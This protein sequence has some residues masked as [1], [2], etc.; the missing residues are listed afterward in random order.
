[1]ATKQ[2]RIYGTR[3]GNLIH[4]RT[5]GELRE[6]ISEA[7]SLRTIESQRERILTVCAWCSGE[8]RESIWKDYPRAQL[9]LCV[10]YLTNVPWNIGM[11]I[12]SNKY[13]PPPPE[14]IQSTSSAT[15][16]K[17]LIATERSNIDRC[18]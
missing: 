17:F 4:S 11:V 3:H 16:F 2:I 6:C 13:D 9:C 8:R 1:M 12:S 18:I 14:M 15:N 5:I 7:P 10:L